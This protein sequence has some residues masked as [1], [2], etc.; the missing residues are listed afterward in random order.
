MFRVVTVKVG[1]AYNSD[2]VNKMY[3]MLKRH[4]KL[5]FE[6][7]CIT[8]DLT[9]IDENIICAWPPMKLSGCWNKLAIFQF[10]NK[11][12]GDPVLYLDLDQVITDDITDLICPYIGSPQMVCYADHIE[13]MGCKFGSAL[14]MFQPCDFYYIWDEFL[15]N[16]DKAIQT[17]GGD[18]VYI[19]TLINPDY[20]IYI[21]EFHPGAIA[22]F[23][24]DLKQGD[25]NDGVKL[26]N[27]HG[28]PKPHE[29][30]VEW[31]KQHWN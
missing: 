14:M 5:D 29:S 7:W 13:W 26:V 25:L 27:F 11:A 18:Q 30:D 4:L 15:A 23:K 8:D 16:Y 21:N 2:Y 22:S 10:F 1:D 28:H 9:G 20:I 3:S 24:Y 19:N 6:M 17:Q 31:I 12:S